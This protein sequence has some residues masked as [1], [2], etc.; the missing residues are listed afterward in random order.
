[1]TIRKKLINILKLFWDNGISYYVIEYFTVSKIKKRVKKTEQTEMEF[2][3]LKWSRPGKRRKSSDDS[4]RVPRYV[5]KYILRRLRTLWT[6]SSEWFV[7]ENCLEYAITSVLWMPCGFTSHRQKRSGL[8]K[9]HTR[10]TSQYE[11][12]STAVAR[13]AGIY[14]GTIYGTRRVRLMRKIVRHRSKRSRRVWPTLCKR[15]TAKTEF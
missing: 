5:P 10:L 9:R 12:V 2:K 15:R 13:N 7:E 11:T 14:L 1:M 3:I 4:P 6:H 8:V